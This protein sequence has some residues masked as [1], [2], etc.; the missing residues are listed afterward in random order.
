MNEDCK[1]H[2]EYYA[3]VLDKVEP[4]TRAKRAVFRIINDHLSNRRGLSQEFGDIDGEIQGEI[5]DSWIAL[6][7]VANG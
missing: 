5:V 1:Y 2:D 3:F 7:E 6:V 4:S